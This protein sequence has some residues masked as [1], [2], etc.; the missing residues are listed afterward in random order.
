MER[1]YAIDLVKFF[2]IFAVVIIHTF[3]ANGEIGY[4]ILD[5]LSRFA[6]PFFFAASGYLFGSKITI[7]SRKDQYFSKYMIK[8]LKLYMYWFA[9]YFIYDVILMYFQGHFQEEWSKY[10]KEFT[11]L[12]IVYYG[13]GTSGYQLWFLP[14]LIW[15]VLAIFTFYRLKLIYLLFLVSLGLNIMG[16]FG[17]SYSKFYQLEVET[18]RD[19]MFFGLFYTTLGFTFA[20]GFTRLRKL[21]FIT[22][23]SLL[24]V[25]F[26]LQA[27]ESYFIDKIRGG[28]HGEYFISTIPLTVMLFLFVLKCKTLGKGMFITRV[29]GKSLGIY[30]IHVFFINL[31]T[32]A[33]NHLGLNH[34]IDNLVWNTSITIF[35]FVISYLAYQL[36]QNAE[37]GLYQ[38]YLE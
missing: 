31:V 33:R 26:L 23:V 10:L 37:R 3:P 25:F 1:N 19:A 28:S 30:V 22:I 9:F 5:N 4:F 32:L 24:A 36:L 8:I 16:L 2:A 13:R 34:L 29:G 6:V 38:K 17:Q 12:N 7:T 20:I 35:I 15:S 27:G 18:T 11:L 14:A 21:S